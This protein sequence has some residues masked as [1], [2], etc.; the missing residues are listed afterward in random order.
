MEGASGVK[1]DHVQTP[2]V[3]RKTAKHSRRGIAAFVYAC[4]SYGHP[5]AETATAWD[6]SVIVPFFDAET[7]QT[8]RDARTPEFIG[9]DA[10]PLDCVR[11]VGIERQGDDRV[12]TNSD[13]PN[14]IAPDH[15]FAAWN[16]HTRTSTR[17]H[18]C[19]GGDL[20]ERKG[21]GKLTVTHAAQE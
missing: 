1:A 7:R 10:L 9:R 11:W 13:V 21:E 6:K 15:T 19:T 4:V 20:K 16:M 8:A 14:A 2:D 18:K 12:Y 17:R 5:P 3:I